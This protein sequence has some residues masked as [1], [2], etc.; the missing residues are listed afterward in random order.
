[1][2]HKPTILLEHASNFL[3]NGWKFVSNKNIVPVLEYKF[4][5]LKSPRGVITELDAF[6]RIFDE[7][8]IEFLTVSAFQHNL[9]LLGYC[10][11]KTHSIGM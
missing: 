3:T 8:V 6:Q 2:T 7:G 11:Q 5:K 4:A 9:I 10:E 1:M